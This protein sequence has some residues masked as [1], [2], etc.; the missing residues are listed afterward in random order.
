MGT[1]TFPTKRDIVTLLNA[2]LGSGRTDYWGVSGLAP[3]RRP[4]FPNPTAN[5]VSV[6]GTIKSRL[7]LFKKVPVRFGLLR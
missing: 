4:S 3:G 5:L 1:L 6:R 7:L 2:F